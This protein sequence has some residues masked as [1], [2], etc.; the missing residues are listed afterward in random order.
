MKL[1][2]LYF[3]EMKR[4]REVAYL[5]LSLNS[6]MLSSRESLIFEHILSSMPIE[7]Q[8]QELKV[9]Q[10]SKTKYS[11]SLLKF[12]YFPFSSIK[13]LVPNFHCIWSAFVDH[14]STPKYFKE[15]HFFPVQ[16]FFYFFCFFSCKHFSCSLELKSLLVF[17]CFFVLFSIYNTPRNGRIFFY[18]TTVFP[19]S[20]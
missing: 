2:L 1:W 10:I 3:L 20:F 18:M 16:F 8:I 7:E 13:N 5:Y 4:I 19:K 9:L 12:Y 15:G 14:V 6:C 11:F 17:C